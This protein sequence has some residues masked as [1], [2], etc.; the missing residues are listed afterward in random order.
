VIQLDGLE[1]G[2]EIGGSVYGLELVVVLV[3]GEEADS[4]GVSTRVSFGEDEAI[5][6][7]ERRS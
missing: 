3:V 4:F 6:W 1:W 7:T 2:V 5:Q